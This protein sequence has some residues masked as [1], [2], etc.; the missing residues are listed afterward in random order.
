MRTCFSQWDWLL[1]VAS[2]LIDGDHTAKMNIALSSAA[3]AAFVYKPATRHRTYALFV[4]QTTM[5][6]ECGWAR[7]CGDQLM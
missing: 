3:D 5:P 2:S 6:N 7:V 1:F 4:L